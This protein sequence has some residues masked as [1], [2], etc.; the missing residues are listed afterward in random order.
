[1]AGIIATNTTLGREGLTTGIDQAGGLSGAPLFKKSLEVV[2]FLGSRLASLPA[3]RLA[4]VG[5]GGIKSPQDVL[6]MLAAGAQMVQLYT[7][8][9]YE[10]PGLV[11]SLN[12][13]LVDFMDAHGCKS[14]QEASKAWASM[15]RA[16]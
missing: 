2:Q 7:A 8:L 13:G 12:S 14:L 5:V 9:I 6:S 10:G 4:L 3:G 16:T 11:K 15:P 1:M